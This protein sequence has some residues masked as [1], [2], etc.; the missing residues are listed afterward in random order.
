MTLRFILTQYDYF[1][2]LFGK[3]L[4]ISLTDQGKFCKTPEPRMRMAFARFCRTKMNKVKCKT[5]IW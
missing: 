5:S 1:V 3:S 4:N 2:Y